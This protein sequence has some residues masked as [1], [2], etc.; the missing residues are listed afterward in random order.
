MAESTMNPDSPRWFMG[1][2]HKNVLFQVRESEGNLVGG[3]M[4]CGA[5]S[6]MIR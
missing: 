5:G 6:G 4:A 1:E 2:S 3:G